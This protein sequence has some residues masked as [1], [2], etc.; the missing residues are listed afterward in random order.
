MT[1]LRTIQ[2][3]PFLLYPA[4]WSGDL[5]SRPVGIHHMRGQ[6]SLGRALVNPSASRIGIATA[7][8]SYFSTIELFQIAQTHF[9]SMSFTQLFN[10]ATLNATQIEH[11]SC[12]NLD[13]FYLKSTI[14]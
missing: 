1:L 2:F 6:L 5:L 3:E 13:F 9:N 14:F 12:T 4:A 8:Y 11:F 10:F 7:S